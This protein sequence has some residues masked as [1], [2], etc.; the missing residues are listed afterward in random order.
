MA[1][2]MGHSCDAQKFARPSASE[3]CI[4]SRNLAVCLLLLLD[5]HVRRTTVYK[6]RV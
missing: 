1:F 5:L 6:D 2:L 3:L 4:L